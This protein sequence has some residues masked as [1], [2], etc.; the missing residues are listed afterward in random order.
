MFGEEPDIAWFVESQNMGLQL[1]NYW[2][3]DNI[4]SLVILADNKK[5]E[6]DFDESSLKSDYFELGSFTRFDFASSD[7]YDKKSVILLL[8]D[9]GQFIIWPQSSVS[10]SLNWNILEASAIQGELWFFESPHGQKFFEVV[11]YSGSENKLNHKQILQIEKNLE[12]HQE[13]LSEYLLDQVGGIWVELKT[14]RW[15]MKIFLDIMFS[16][17]PEK[18][19]QN[20][21]NYQS[22]DKYFEFEE[23]KYES[24]ENEVLTKW[25][26]NDLGKW[27]DKTR[28]WEKMSDR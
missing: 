27:F 16:L 25:L 17:Y 1:V 5:I 24:L 15:F 7:I 6:Y 20:V 21:L 19:G 9:Y 2:W 23:E 22:F 13:N 3:T 8:P 4:A 28:F 10:I 26:E 18:Y 12:N 11:V 14:S